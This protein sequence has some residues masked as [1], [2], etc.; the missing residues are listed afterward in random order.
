MNIAEFNFFSRFVVCLYFFFA[1]L[2]SPA[3]GSVFSDSLSL[4][5]FSLSPFSSFFQC[6]FFLYPLSLSLTHTLSLSLSHTHND[7]FSFSQFVR[8]SFSISFLYNTI[9]FPYKLPI[10]TIPFFLSLFLLHLLLPLLPCFSH[11]FL[12]ISLFIVRPLTQSYSNPVY[13][14]LTPLSLT[15]KCLRTP[16]NL[17]AIC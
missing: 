12:A 7:L 6:S 5:S 9:S 15:P 1:S 14:I 2:A 8:I 16:P 10:S 3:F 11:P 13:L 4:F 17:F